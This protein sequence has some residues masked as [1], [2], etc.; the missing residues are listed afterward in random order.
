M[1][2]IRRIFSF[3]RRDPIFKALNTCRE[4]GKYRGETYR[5]LCRTCA[6]ALHAVR[7][8]QERYYAAM[9]AVYIKATGKKPLDDFDAFEEWIKLLS[10]KGK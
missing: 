3:L 2:T 1:K 10:E 9:D 4:C 5:G 6:P 8:A 7:K